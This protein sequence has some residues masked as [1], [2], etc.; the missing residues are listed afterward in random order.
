[1]PEKFSPSLSPTFAVTPL[2]QRT[3]KV[4]VCSSGAVSWAPRGSYA[5][6]ATDPAVN[7]QL[8]AT[9]A[10][11]ATFTGAENAASVFCE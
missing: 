2:T 9:F 1:M 5:P 4:P 11:I 8:A 6:N 10:E 3:V 7:T